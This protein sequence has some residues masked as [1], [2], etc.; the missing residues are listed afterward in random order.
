VLVPDRELIAG[1]RM[2]SSLEVVVPGTGLA[3]TTSAVAGQGTYVRNSVIYASVVG[4]KRVSQQGNKTVIEVVPDKP[5][6]PLPQIGDVVTAKVTKISIKMAHVS[7]LAIGLVV[8]KEPMVGI[9]RS[10]DVRAFEID[11]VEMYK[12]FRPGDVIRAEVISLGDSKS[13]YLSTAK[14]ELGVILA[15]SASGHTMVPISWQQMQCPVTKIKEYRKV[16][17][18]CE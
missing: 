5:A 4:M 11:T 13:Y 6:T 8:L 1:S 3:E 7:I 16:A 15:Q 2:S 14:N 18:V 17:K 12:S 10:R 9:V